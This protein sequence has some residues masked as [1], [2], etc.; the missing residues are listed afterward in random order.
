M[1]QAGQLILAGAFPVACLV[2]V[3]AM[4]RVEDSLSKRKLK[5]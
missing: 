1:G 4:G 5:R 3:L 2:T